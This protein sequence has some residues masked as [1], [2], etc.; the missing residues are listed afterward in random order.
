MK[1]RKSQQGVALVVTLILLSVITFMAVTFLV[2]SRREGERV[3]TQSNQSNAKFAADAALE[4]AKGSIIAPMLAHNNGLN[5]GL[6]VST[7]YINPKGFVSG[8]SAAADSSPTNVSY[9]D[10]GGFFLSGNNML[11][12]L[13]NLQILPRAPVFVTTNKLLPPDFRYYVDLNRNGVYDTNGFGTNYYGGLPVLDTNSN[14]VTTTFVGD[15]EWVGILEK[16]EQPHSSSNRFIARYAFLAQPIGNSLDINHIYNQAKQI[17]IGKDGFLRDHGFGSWEINLAGFLY[18]LNTNQWGAAYNYSINAG[19]LS[20]GDAFADALGILRYRYKQTYANLA[21][22]NVLYGVTPTKVFGTKDLLDGY[23]HGPVMTDIHLPPSLPPGTNDPDLNLTGTPWPGADNPRHFFSSQDLFSP[24]PNQFQS[25]SNHLYSAGT[26]LLDSAQRYTFYKLLEQMGFES[27]PEDASKINLNYVNV[28]GTNATNYI[29]W[30]PVQFFT[31]AAD[32]LLKNL[33]AGD[34]TPRPPFPQYPTNFGIANIPIYPINYYTPAV[35]R[36]LQLAANI[37]DASYT[38]VGNF[39]SVFRPIFTNAPGISNIPNISII[40]YVEETSNTVAYLNQPLSLPEEASKVNS[41]TT[42]IYG[43]PWIIGAKKGFPNFNELAMTSVSQI[44]RRLQVDKGNPI[45][46]RA[47]WDIREMYQIGVSNV[48]GVEAWNSYTNPFSRL[49]QVTIADDLRMSLTVTN[50]GSSTPVYTTNFPTLYLPPLYVLGTVYPVPANTWQGILKPQPVSPMSFLTYRS[51]VF[52]VPDYVYRQ[53]PPGLTTN[54]FFQTISPT[55]PHFVLGATNRFRFIIRDVNSGRIID[56]VQL[57][58]I[59]LVRDL[60]EEARADDPFGIWGTNIVNYNNINMPAGIKGQLQI[61]QGVDPKDAWDKAQIGA[62]QGDTKIQAVNAFGEFFNDDGTGGTNFSPVP[63]SPTAKFYQSLTWQANDPLVHYTL[64]DLATSFAPENKPQRV[65]FSEGSGFTTNI[66]KNIGSVNSRYHPWNYVPNESSDPGLKDLAFKD[67]SPAFV[68]GSDDWDFPTNKF[69][70]I[71]WLG[72]VHRGTPWQTVYLK[73][74]TVAPA[75]WQKWTGNLDTNSAVLTQPMNDWKLFDL[76]TVAP[77]EN[78]SRGR[79]SINQTNLAAWAAIFQGVVTLTNTPTIPPYT[80]LT[81]DPVAN[82]AAFR[83]IWNGINARR[84]SL[85]V[86]AAGQVTTN[87][88]YPGQVF[89]NLGDI[90]SVPELSINSP[91]LNT[92]TA[93]AG[94]IDAVYERL[95]QQVLSLLKVGEPRYVI[96]SYGQSLKPADRS[97]VQKSGA[98]FGMCT[99]Y[100]ITGEVATRT[101]LRIDSSPVPGVATLPRPKVVVESFNVLPPD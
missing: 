21:P 92:N 25:F 29:S 88:N 78:A 65:D 36:M 69:P 1:C 93:P 81:I 62:A 83:T 3:V 31:N 7:N 100:Q 39:P 35:H 89:T 51:N 54:N 64:G 61:A 58:S 90:L 22:F 38:N 60:T 14:P 32:K 16:P 47:N 11:R 97:I 94:L 46:P 43:F 71:G 23:A 5:F 53:S 87:Y 13:N 44:T 63:F 98:Y 41:T 24:D 27:A 86:N 49:V 10:P 18:Y 96:Y 77:N 57:D 56:Y 84:A 9:T 19:T 73:S 33:A 91:F 66:I 82:D 15:P 80:A 55:P 48:F 28:N 40:G 75:T 17:N 50:A 12:M 34:T 20:S 68:G 26:N 101:V 6:V 76:F 67:P 59:G 95:P 52:F 70:N 4:Q 72:R 85:F 79:L 74:A 42:N 2:V 8:I 45:K 30:T 99:N 37:Y